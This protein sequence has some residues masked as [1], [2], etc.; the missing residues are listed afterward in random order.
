MN[1]FK[2]SPQVVYR[3]TVVLWCLLVLSH[4]SWHIYSVLSGPPDS[5]TYANEWQFQVMV[6][7]LLKLPYWLGALLTTL[8][9]EFFF[10][11]QHAKPE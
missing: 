8:L 11:G 1:T 5:D 7:A 4:A 2:R 10:I 6:F 9:L 3:A